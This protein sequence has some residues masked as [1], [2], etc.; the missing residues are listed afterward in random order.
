MSTVYS[1]QTAVRM[2]FN[3]IFYWVNKFNINTIIFCSEGGKIEENKYIVH[4]KLIDIRIKI[5]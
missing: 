1:Q 2:F 5:K 4:I 3:Q